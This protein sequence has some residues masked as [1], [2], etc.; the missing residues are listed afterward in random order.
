[1]K[2]AQKVAAQVLYLC[3]LNGLASR[4]NKNI[5]FFAMPQ[6]LLLLPHHHSRPLPADGIFGGFK[7]VEIQGYKV[8]A[9]WWLGMNSCPSFVM[10]SCVFKVVCD[11]T[12]SCWSISVTFLWGLTLL[13]SWCKV[14]RV[15]MYRSELIV[16]HDIMYTR[17][18]PSASQKHWSWLLSW[19]GSLNSIPLRRSRMGLFH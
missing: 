3:Q 15:W 7:E 11:S 12:L 2:V 14:L 18:T 9:V 10:A 8:W 17:I 16:W 6:P 19:I 1:M 4:R 13:A 5:Y